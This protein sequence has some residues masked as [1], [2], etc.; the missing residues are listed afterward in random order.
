MVRF[1]FYFLLVIQGVEGLSFFKDDD[2]QD[3]GKGPTKVNALMLFLKFI[4]GLSH[5]I[6]IRIRFINF[7]T[8]LHEHDE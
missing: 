8:R 7:F 5:A 6:R 1:L 4:L 3:T 2:P